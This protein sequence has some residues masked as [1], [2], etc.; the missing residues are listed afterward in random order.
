MF[1]LCGR[2]GQRTYEPTL[3]PG[4][5]AHLGREGTIW[6]YSTL[7]VRL[8]VLAPGALADELARLASEMRALAER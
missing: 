2:G 1:L 3:P 8:S 5:C 6:Y 4:K 7:A